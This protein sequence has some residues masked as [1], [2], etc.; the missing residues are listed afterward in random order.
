MKSVDILIKNAN[1]IL[2][3]RGPKRARIG[4]EMAELGIIKNG[5]VAIGDGKIVDVG[6]G[7]AK[8]SADKIIDAKG[9]IVIPGFVDPHTHLAFSG[10]RDFEVEM[11]LEGLSYKEIARKGGGIQ[12]TVK[13]TRKA[14]KETLL[15]ETKERLDRMLLHGTTTCEA[16]SGY[17]LD[18]NNELKILEVYR[19]LNS[20]HPVDVIPTF[21]GAHAVPSEYGNV[22]EY[23]NLIVEEMI[24]KVADKKLARFCDVFCEKGYFDLE[25]SKRVLIAGK[26]RGL[27]PKIHADEF[28][29]LG[30]SKLASEIKAVSA[31]HLLKIPDEAV[32]ELSK[33]GT[34]AVL[35]PATVFS[36]MSKDFAPARKLIDSGVPVAL[37]TDLNPNCYT[38]NMQFVIQLACFYMRMKPTEAIVA[39]TINAAYSIGEGDKVGSIERGKNADVLIMDAPSYTFL[40]YHFGI[41]LVHT[42]IKSGEVVYTATGF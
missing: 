14:S 7:E 41:N 42:V 4:R 35:L 39:S 19:E 12:Y 9:K 32:S 24:P 6:K 1:E 28:T 22:S 8:F 10:C 37:G 17:G 2:T 5:Y 20:K 30:C 33:S 21:L 36:L 16:K 25:H 26:E 11:K 38:E 3:L 23:V 13:L 29:S 31:D 40:F 18:L 27:L 15:E 34:I